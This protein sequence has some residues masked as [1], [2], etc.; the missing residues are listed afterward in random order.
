MNMLDPQSNPTSNDANLAMLID[1]AV[2]TEL[3]ELLGDELQDIVDQFLTSLD[4]DLCSLADA[5]REPDLDAAA[6]HAHAIKGSAGNLGLNALAACA[7]DLERLSRGT[8]ADTAERSF[9]ALRSTAT[10]TLV[11]LQ[12]MGLA[13]QTPEAGS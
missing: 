10:A 9:S 2:L 5:V 12:C 6:R 1:E 4:E 8:N 7:A 3:R 13:R 11:R